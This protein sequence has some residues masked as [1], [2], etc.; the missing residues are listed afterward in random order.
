[1]VLKF[2]HTFLNDH[3]LCVCSDE[4]VKIKNELLDEDDKLILK[5]KTSQVI[6][7]LKEQNYYLNAKL[8]IPDSYPEGLLM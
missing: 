1:M 8:L 4:I 5:Q 3:P 6:V 7:K 2:V